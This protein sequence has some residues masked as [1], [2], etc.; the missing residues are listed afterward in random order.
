M[1]RFM[2]NTNKTSYVNRTS[3]KTRTNYEWSNPEVEIVK[4]VDYYIPLKLQRIME[5]LN[6][7]FTGL[8]FSIC[9]KT[10]T[11]PTL[12]ILTLDVDFDSIFVPSQIVSGAAIDYKEEVPLEYN[13][14]IHKHPN[15]CTHFSG[16][17]TKYINQNFDYSLLWVNNTFHRGLIRSSCEF[18][19][20]NLDLKFVY[21]KE[22]FEDIPKEWID[23]ILRE[24]K[25]TGFS[26][27]YFLG[28]FGMNYK[29]EK[30][31]LKKY[32]EENDLYDGF[33][34]ISQG[35]GIKKYQE[36]DEDVYGDLSGKNPDKDIEEYQ[37]EDDDI[38]DFLT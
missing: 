7:K 36:E 2:P 17:D 38:Y 35:K 15:G 8:E 21:Q 12:G 32:Q 34:M 26:P 20:I 27:E 25:R 23:K 10:Y 30:D 14:V 9:G 24:P 11:D 16:Q 22:K 28:G 13:T 3:K 19:L 5:A 33:G 6:N 29:A 4:S 18:G 37:E 31:T 1:K